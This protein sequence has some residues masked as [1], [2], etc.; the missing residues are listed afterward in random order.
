MVV[1]EKK[2]EFEF[3][4]LLVE[5]HTRGK[6][7]LEKLSKARFFTEFENRGLFLRCYAAGKKGH[8]FQTP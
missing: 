5:L 3:C 1:Y 2:I 8:D 7:I 6:D 4:P